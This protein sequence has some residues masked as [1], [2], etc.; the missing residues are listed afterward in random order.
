MGKLIIFI[1]TQFNSYLGFTSSYYFLPYGYYD[2]LEEINVVVPKG[3]NIGASLKNKNMLFK[4]NLSFIKGRT[5]NYYFFQFPYTSIKNTLKF[6][7][8]YREI[9]ALP[10][11]SLKEFDFYFGPGILFS[12]IDFYYCEKTSTY[13][14]DTLKKVEYHGDLSGF[15][16]IFGVEKE[17]FKKIE[18][19]WE[20]YLLFYGI[21]NLGWEVKDGEKKEKN[22]LLL[23]G[24]LFRSSSEEGT[25]N[26]MTIG[27]KYKW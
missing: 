21:L 13:S 8:I 9:S 24:L 7:E 26:R 15:P 14:G 25:L 10:Y 2:F 16:L 1:Y 12:A 18:I 22:F 4:I 19:F 11:V 5:E 6:N 17:I 23:G 27:I 3:V 20:T